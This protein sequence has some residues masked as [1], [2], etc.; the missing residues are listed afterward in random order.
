MIYALIN[1]NTGQIRKRGSACKDQLHKLPCYCI[2][3]KKNFWDKTHREFCVQIKAKRTQIKI[4]KHTLLL[5]AYKCIHCMLTHDYREY[6]RDFPLRRFDGPM[7]L[8]P[9]YVK[10]SSPL[11][12]NYKGAMSWNN[13]PVEMRLIQTSNQFKNMQ[14]KLIQNLL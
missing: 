11:H 2:F 14:K 9:D 8:V 12:I 6:V 7:L 4:E 5:Y 1:T 10:I 3:F 13:L